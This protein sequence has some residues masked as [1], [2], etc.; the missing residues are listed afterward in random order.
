MQSM[1]LVPVVL[2]LLRVLSLLGGRRV[3]PLPAPKNMFI[4][5]GRSGTVALF[6]WGI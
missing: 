4:S 6:L 1:M 3:V 5:C 2:T